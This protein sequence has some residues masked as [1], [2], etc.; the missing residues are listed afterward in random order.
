MQLSPVIEPE[1]VGG[2]CLGKGERDAGEDGLGAVGR[3]QTASAGRLYPAIIP[4]LLAGGADGEA[5]LPALRCVQT[6]SDLPDVAQIG[7]LL[8]ASRNGQRRALAKL[9]SLPA[10]DAGCTSASLSVFAC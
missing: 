2:S 7:P 3:P 4:R 1:R 8:D 10:E 9:A 5:A 6:A